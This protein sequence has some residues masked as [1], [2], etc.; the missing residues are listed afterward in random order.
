MF[1]QARPT[2]FDMY[3]RLG[4]I[5]VRVVPWFWVITILM[6]YRGTMPDRPDLL[7]TWMGCVFISILVHELG[8]AI[9]GL[10]FGWHPEVWLYHF[11]G[12]ASFRD[13]P[14]WTVGKNIVMLFAG[15]WAGFLLYGLVVLGEYLFSG[16]IRNA[17]V[18]GVVTDGPQ[19]YRIP[20]WY[21]AIH[22]LKYINLYWG[23]VN[24]LPVFPLDGGQIAGTLL[25]KYRYRDG[26]ELTF[27]L[28]IGVGIAAAVFFISQ[29][30]RYPAFLFGYLAFMNYQNLEMHRRGYY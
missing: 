20:W 8:H 18:S 16:E 13:Q 7:L 6:G 1:G 28:G 30:R 24:L 27:K 12:Y 3:F 21:E 4:P 17:I 22:Q 11:G 15:P 5:P 10:A 29:E 14:N 9:A 2:A 26:R 25:E 23:L 19:S